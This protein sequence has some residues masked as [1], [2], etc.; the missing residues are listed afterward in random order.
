VA[1]GRTKLRIIGNPV[2][3][4]NV[5]GDEKESLKSLIKF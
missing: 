3:G 5:T 1:I 4:E 2:A